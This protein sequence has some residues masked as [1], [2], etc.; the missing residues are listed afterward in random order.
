MEVITNRQT[1]LSYKTV[2]SLSRKT[3]IVQF[4]EK[5]VLIMEDTFCVT[6]LITII[7]ISPPMQPTGKYHQWDASH[8]LRSTGITCELTV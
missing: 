5:L 1:I 3:I 7:E 4:N 6:E 2:Y 8:R